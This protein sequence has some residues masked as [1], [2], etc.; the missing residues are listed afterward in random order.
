MAS[1][2]MSFGKLYRNSSRSVWSIRRQLA[3]IP[4]SNSPNDV[5]VRGNYLSS[6]TITVPLR[7]ASITPTDSIYTDLTVIIFKGFPASYMTTTTENSN[8]FYANDYTNNNQ[9]GI[10]C[11]CKSNGNDVLTSGFNYNTLETFALTPLLYFHGNPVINAATD[12]LVTFSNP[13]ITAEGKRMENWLQS[14]SATDWGNRLF[15]G[16]Y[17]N[18]TAVT[19]TNGSTT[20]IDLNWVFPY[21]PSDTSTMTQ[22]IDL[23]LNYGS[24]IVKYHNG[25]EWVDCEALYYDGSEWK[26]CEAKYYDGSEW[27]VLG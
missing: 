16:V 3:T 2:T 20:G 15:V 7:G 4:Y 14:S 26:Q 5:F 12:T 11:V 18:S 23:T 22:Y 1:T 17:H 19:W 27:K 9:T 25:S 8:W 21:L 6:A 10:N 13:E 24:G